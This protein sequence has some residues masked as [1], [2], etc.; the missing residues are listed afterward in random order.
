MTWRESFPI[1]KAHPDLIYLDHAATAQK[2]QY[3]IDR[4]T[5][6][7]ETENASPNRGAYGLSASATITYE[8][9]REAVLK[10]IDA[11]KDAAAIFTKNA[12]EALNLVAYA[13]PFR[14]GDEIVVAIS[15]HHSIIVPMQIAAKR[16]GA[17]LKYLYVDGVHG[18]FS[19]QILAVIG[20]KT[21]LVALPLIDNAL[22]VLYDVETV[23]KK[24]RQH[25]AAVLVDAAQAVGHRPVSMQK[26]DADFLVFSGHKMYGPQGIGVLAAKYEQLEQMTPF[27]AGGDM[28]AY[29]TEQSTTYAPIPKRFE[30][31]T[32]N[33]G[34]AVGL[35]AAIQWIDAQGLD[36]IAE[37][38][39][40]M[41]RYAL[42]RLS[43]HPAVTVLG[44]KLNMARGAL[45][46]FEVEGIHPH[47]MA[48]LLD[49]NGIA[50]RAGHHCCQPYMH[51]LDKAGTCRA[52]FSAFT[53][54]R[55]IDA[56]I[57]GIDHARK[58]FG[59][60]RS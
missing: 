12:T 52:S 45:V 4:M 47:D 17:V 16:A 29:V 6:W 49:Q 40:A 8:N 35:E 15:S 43:E 22:G 30:A 23:V 19:E 9:A 20:P 38:E 36:R 7:Y 60:D 34:G 57:M 14:P 56:L 28:I 5:A 48:T 46:S 54:E 41:T 31:G 2:P 44:P 1:L 25:G 42:L 59:Y 18:D 10:F 21:R 50:I 37:R 3:V 24:A 33:V 32:Q 26:L 58:V 39:A 13:Y 51:H 53:E 27:L 11:G 55:D